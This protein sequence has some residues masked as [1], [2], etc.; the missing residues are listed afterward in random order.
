MITI[1]V[2]ILAVVQGI[3]EFLPISSSGHLALMQYYLGMHTLSGAALEVALHAG[4]LVSIIVFYHKKI[5]HLVAGVFQRK[6]EDIE[7]ITKIVL[8][9]VPA[10]LFYFLCNDFLESSFDSPMMVSI[11]L[12]CTGGI[13]LSLL[14]LTRK[15]QK[16]DKKVGF[17]HS[18]V[19]G[20]AQA[21]A[22]LPGISRSGSTITA[23]S[24]MKISRKEAAE[25][26][27]LMSLPVIGGAILLKCRDICDLTKVSD[28]IG[29]GDL[30]CGFILS[31][32]VGIA[33]L[34]LLQKLLLQG[35]FW[36]FGVYCSFAG[37]LSCLWIALH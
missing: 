6:K 1:D 31:A 37:M 5:E 16:Q 12:M 29:M 8:S 9:A 32:A 14:F 20:I 23:S 30:A 11:C 19:I 4:T 25:F 3:A 28:G 15:N 2:M 21:A 7:Y 26:S 18:L 35:K 17:G 24:W 34:A 27:F 33:A 10:G 13:L 22:I 36:V